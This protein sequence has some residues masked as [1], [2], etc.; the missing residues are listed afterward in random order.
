[1]TQTCVSLAPPPW[2]WNSVLWWTLQQLEESWMKGKAVWGNHQI[3]KYLKCKKKKNN[4]RA[5]LPG[6]SGSVQSWTLGAS[7][8]GCDGCS[9]V[10]FTKQREFQTPRMLS[11]RVP[12]GVWVSTSIL[13]S[14]PTHRHRE[15]PELLF[16]MDFS[17]QFTNPACIFFTAENYLS[18][19]V[20]D[21]F[22]SFP[23][24]HWDK[25]RLEMYNIV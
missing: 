2:V 14:P 17:K 7:R 24:H 21:F 23:Q 9:A 8:P 25:T 12:S 20:K 10:M 3:N 11:G 4:G 5:E 13:W 1:M 16:F 6:C 19:P 15:S 18:N 22:F